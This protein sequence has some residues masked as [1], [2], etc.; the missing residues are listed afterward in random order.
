MIN[1]SNN[2][3]FEFVN[4]QE[5]K[6]KLSPKKT[7]L[8]IAINDEIFIEDKMLGTGTHGTASIYRS[9]DRKKCVVVKSFPQGSSTQ[10]EECKKEA[11]LNQSIH[12]MGGF[13]LNESNAMCILMPYFNGPELNKYTVHS[14]NEFIELSISLV[15]EVEKFHHTVGYIHGD[16]RSGN[17]IIVHE[18]VLVSPRSQT[19]V[20]LIDFG[21]SSPLGTEKKITPEEFYGLSEAQ[22]KEANLPPIPRDVDKDISRT[23]G[24]LGWYLSLCCKQKLVDFDKEIIQRLE[25]IFKQLKLDP[26]L[27]LAKTK[28]EL[29]ELLTQ[30][31]EKKWPHFQE[32]R[33]SIANLID[34]E[35]ERLKTKL[36]NNSK[37]SGEKLAHFEHLRELLNHDL[38]E[39]GLVTVIKATAIV[40]H[41]KRK[42]SSSLFTAAHSW[43]AWKTLLNVLPKDT[44][45]FNVY[46]ESLSTT[47]RI[48]YINN[49]AINNYDKYRIAVPSPEK[50]NIEAKFTPDESDSRLSF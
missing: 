44:A 50:P 10:L 47:G 45:Y 9:T 24:T 33:H 35:I 19:N 1:R 6:K 32:T 29:Y 11:D 2:T 3:L 38:N 27:G 12:G 4:I 30:T 41:H 21:E 34:Q 14:L 28:K 26:D 18:N 5:N 37:G 15:E 22:I 49:E 36:H 42:Q 39:A 48:I 16:V 23:A 13:T 17:T 25:N 43:D 46:Q 7:N 31:N 40:C 8:V 20:K